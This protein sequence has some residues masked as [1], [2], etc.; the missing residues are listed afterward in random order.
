MSSQCAPAINSMIFRP[1]SRRTK[2][3]PAAAIPTNSHIRG[4]LH[5]GRLRRFAV[6]YAGMKPY[7][8]QDAPSR[9]GSLIPTRYRFC[10]LISRQERPCRAVTPKILLGSRSSFSNEIF[11]IFRWKIEGPANLNFACVKKETYTP[12]KKTEHTH[13]TDMVFKYADPRC[14]QCRLP[15][16]R[17][18]GLCGGLHHAGLDQEGLGVLGQGHRL[19]PC[20][21]GVRGALPLGY[22]HARF[23]QGHSKCC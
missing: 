4:D 1:L 13:P 11:S 18:E 7:P 20:I 9:Q 21:D 22:L 12:L 10:A 15:S 3:Q 16:Y 5:D 8:K 23:G 19:R 2:D 6:I 14:E 17:F